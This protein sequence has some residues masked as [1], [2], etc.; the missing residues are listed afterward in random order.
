MSG[1]RMFEYADM[2][3]N[4]AGVLCALMLVHTPLSRALHGIERSFLR[5]IFTETK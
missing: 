5:F 3:A 1:Y 4:A 2:A